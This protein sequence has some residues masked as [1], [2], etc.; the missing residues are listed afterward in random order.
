VVPFLTHWNHEKNDLDL[1]LIFRDLPRIPGNLK[2]YGALHYAAADGLHLLPKPFRQFVD[3][4]RLRLDQLQGSSLA[5][6][7]LVDVP[8][9]GRRARQK[10]VDVC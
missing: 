7:R 3:L 5:G 4:D 8:S 1:V 6:A 2:D 10:V 9:A